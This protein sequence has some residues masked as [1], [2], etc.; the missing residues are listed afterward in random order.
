M[1]VDVFAG[2]IKCTL[3]SDDFQ[4][5]LQLEDEALK[6]IGTHCPELVTLNL[7]TCSVSLVNMN[8]R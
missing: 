6:H 2:I 1:A 7:Q 4:S 3:I 5:F 8:R